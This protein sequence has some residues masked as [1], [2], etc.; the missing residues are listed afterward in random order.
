MRKIVGCFVAAGIIACSVPMGI[1]HADN[2]KIV[3]RTELP[4]VLRYTVKSQGS[5][6]AVLRL[7]RSRTVSSTWSGEVGV[8]W[9]IINASAGYSVNKSESIGYESQR[10]AS[11]PKKCYTIR[12]SDLME[13]FKLKWHYDGWLFMPDDDGTL[14]IRHQYGVVF[15]HPWPTKTSQFGC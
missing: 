12:A 4:K 15:D 8:S 7:S 5:K 9:K 14:T 13:Q 1:G 10:D 6:G 2:A 11:D 3:Q